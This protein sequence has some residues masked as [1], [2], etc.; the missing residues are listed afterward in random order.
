MKHGPATQKQGA[1]M[2]GFVAM[3]A[4]PVKRIQ[5]SR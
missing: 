1:A 2:R 4:A 5:I 3:I